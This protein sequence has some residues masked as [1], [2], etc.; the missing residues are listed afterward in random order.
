M[1]SDHAQVPAF[2]QSYPY[3]GF[4]LQSGLTGRWWV[5]GQWIDGP[6][7]HEYDARRWV[8]GKTENAF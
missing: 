2:A 5:V 7:E 1:H 6:F 3:K 8:E 4:Y